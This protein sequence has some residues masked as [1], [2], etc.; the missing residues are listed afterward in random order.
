MN[1]HALSLLQFDAVRH[2]VAGLTLG[3]PGER[4]VLEGGVRTDPEA[5]D[6]M[7]DLVED[8]RTVLVQTEQVPDAAFPDIV[9]LFPVLQKEG[10]VLDAEQLAAV[11]LFAAAV[12][13]FSRAG[14]E[15]EDD[16]PLA[17]RLAD[18]PDLSATR[19]RI[20]AFITDVG[21]VREDAVPE[22]ARLRSRI[23]ERE[24]RIETRAAAYL[25]DP[26][27]AQYWTSDAPTQRNGRTVLPLSA[28][29]RGRVSGIVH[30]VSQTGATLFVEPSD[31]V[32]LNNEVREAR[33]AYDQEVQRI[34]RELTG[35][36]RAALPELRTAEAETAELDA[37]LAR[38]RY[39]MSHGCVRACRV[40]A[41]GGFR[42]SGARH[43]LLRGT[44]V[45]IDAH[46][47]PP[48]RGLIVTGPNTG[49]KTVA[50][51]TVGLL[52]LMNQFGLE[53]P[54]DEGSSL[55]VFDEV[56]ADIGDEQSLEQSLSTFSGHMTTIA[57]VLREAGAGSLVLLDELGAGT[58]PEEGSALAM[59]ILDEIERIGATAFVTTHHGAL[60]NYAYRSAYFE[61]ASVEF[62]A[63]RLSPTYHLLIGVPGTSHAL[64]IAERNGLP[65][66]LV[67]RARGYVEEGQGEE[68]RIIRDLTEK[69][70]ELHRTTRARAAE[71]ENLRRDRERLAEQSQELAARELRLRREGLQEFERLSRET[72]QRLENLVREIRE[73]ELTREKTSRVREFLDEISDTAEQHKEEVVRREQEQAEVRRE[74]EGPPPELAPG[75]EVTV[76][77]SG[78]RGV[79]R[80]RGKGDSWVVET[81][82]IRLELP[83]EQLRPAGG[84]RGG[85]GGRREVSYDPGGA[86]APSLELD[87]RG[88]RLPDAL[89]AVDRQ[90]D[91]CLLSGVDQF[92]IIHGKGQGILQKGIRDHLGGRPEVS[93]F[94][95]ARPEE[96]GYG[97]T[98]V[99]LRET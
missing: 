95:F 3:A 98:V 16:R 82:S 85:T 45:P 86:A 9:P 40:S 91:A 27:R 22:L 92:S 67:R 29:Y 52:A 51:K 26:N 61:N 14:A 15:M 17:R 12:R 30:E 97:K 31:L 46:I 58:D 21:E 48:Q 83:A 74:A 35:E 78:R 90:L 71:L 79:I 87:V 53:I 36:L 34:L 54:A 89:Q 62:D 7:L 1:E 57:S 25:R 55:P 80:R 10:T 88:Y 56:Y 99:H 70:V 38:A 44:V 50:L 39:G 75:M 84:N 68:T 81:E 42:L 5:I 60:K 8:W 93:E 66:A 64:E 32:D 41:D 2:A 77:E 59:S 96:G 65:G 24:A 33:A 6:G 76:G 13:T 43:P 94:D 11:S 19:K 37:V 49:G 20:S 69:Q 23:R 63:E 73:G 4:A 18:L 72:R 47:D 28:N